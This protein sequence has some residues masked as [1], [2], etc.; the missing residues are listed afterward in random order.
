[1]IL[2]DFQVPEPV[3]DKVE[4]NKCKTMLGDIVDNSKKLFVS[5]ILR[6]TVISI[7][8]NFT[9]HIGYYGLMMWFPELFNRF[10]EFHRDHPGEVASICEV[11]DYVVK[12]GSHN[13]ENLCSDKIGASVFLESLITV[14][15]AIPA[16]IIAVLGMDRLGRKFFLGKHHISFI[17]FN[18]DFI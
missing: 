13:V 4:K 2:D 15:S 1:M 14:A 10:D 18:I 3:K 7:I 6:F 9:F 11:T 12:K 17:S 8:I 16:N 5:P